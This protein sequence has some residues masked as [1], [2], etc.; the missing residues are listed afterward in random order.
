MSS[1]DS[2]LNVRPDAMRVIKEGLNSEYILS[3]PKYFGRHFLTLQ[4]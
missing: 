2:E 4:M 1:S 3:R